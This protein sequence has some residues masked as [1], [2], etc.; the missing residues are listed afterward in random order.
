MAKPIRLQRSRARGSRLT[1]PNGLPVV[2]VTRPG[3]WGNPFKIGMSSHEAGEAAARHFGV[4]VNQE[5]PLNTLSDVIA[6]YRWCVENFRRKSVMELRGHN[7]ACFC[8]LDKACHA[9]VLLELA[10]APQRKARQ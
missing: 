9:D 5:D 1:S 8:G 7:L 2:C 6:M 4:R 3:K 10:N